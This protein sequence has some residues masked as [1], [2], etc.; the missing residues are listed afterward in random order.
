MVSKI[1]TRRSCSVA[2]RPGSK[3]D[4]MSSEADARRTDLDVTVVMI[5]KDRAEEA[6]R[7]VQRLLALPE[8]AHIVVV[9]NGSSQHPVGVLEHLDQRVRVI[10]LGRNAG[11]AGR[12]IGVVAA[13]RELMELV[14]YGMRDGHIR[15]LT[16]TAA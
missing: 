9:D 3:H 1:A 10:R 7:A 8:R 5:T 4:M 2:K 11:A 14:F 15:C 6:Q 16:R 13:A 12:N